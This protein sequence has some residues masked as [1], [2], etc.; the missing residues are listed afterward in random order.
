MAPDKSFTE[1]TSGRLVLRRF[2]PADLDA[3]VA[4]RSVPEVARYQGW[5]APFPRD[6]GEQLIA[7]M[8]SQHPGTPGEWFQFAVELRVTGTLIGDC[9]CC[10][11]ADMPRSAEI[12]FTIA[13]AHQGHGYGTEAVQ[14]LLGYLFGKLDLHRV[15]A[16]CDARNTASAALMERAGLRREGHQ[17]E[18]YWSKGE[19]TDELRYAILAREWRAAQ[20]AAPE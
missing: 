18:S 9:G 20:P 12:G 2:Q 1:L 15:S 6:K 11:D 19:W 16:G 7:E 10:A 17:I 4:Y 8:A 3:F 14:T 5:D 13:P